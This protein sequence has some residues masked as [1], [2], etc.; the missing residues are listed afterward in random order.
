MNI[1]HPPANFFR[2]IG[3]HHAN[4]PEQKRSVD[5]DS[6]STEAR[7]KP[8]LDRIDVKLPDRQITPFEK[9][10]VIVRA[11]GSQLPSDGGWFQI[12]IPGQ[13]L[14]EIRVITKPKGDV[15]SEGKSGEWHIELQAPVQTG[16]HWI[17]VTTR[18]MESEQRV[19]NVAFTV[20]AIA[21]GGLIKLIV[22]SL[23]M[24]TVLGVAWLIFAGDLEKVDRAMI[25]NFDNP[26]PETSPNL[27]KQTTST[28]QIPKPKAP[29]AAK[30]H[31][32]ENSYPIASINALLEQSLYAQNV[33]VR[34]Q[35]W[36]ELSRFIDLQSDE[37]N[38]QI[39]QII[40][41][42]SH[43]KQQT[44]SWLKSKENPQ[45]SIKRLQV[46]AYVDD[47]PSAQRWLGTLY[48]SGRIVMQHWGKAW[49][50]YQRAAN[51]G[52]TNAQQLLDELE[53]RADQLLY[54]PKL[55]EHLHA[56][57]LAEAAASAGGL[58]AQLWLGYR[59]ETGDG[60]RPDYAMAAYWY[61]RA[62]AQGNTQI[63][64]K[65]ARISRLID[66]Q[67]ESK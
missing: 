56:Y 37:D 57:E 38:P 36:R 55:E 52:D 48:A 14:P 39:Q 10:R 1:D 50:W 43:Y 54:S 47:D 45:E 27:N 59:Y 46:L 61:R 53:T 66:R 29:T 60:V 12:A 4:S 9:F 11:E 34:Q 30:I 20:K 42:R 51:Q 8:C 41:K 67:N 3:N 40:L 16:I 5:V 17:N 2:S 28:T 58:N 18:L 64:E 13:R 22:W 15:L 35:A 62:A 65:L 31:Q 19:I 33:D 49:Q 44:E 21:Q 32:Q 7:I 25:W 63:N 24:S 6:K 23:C 26:K